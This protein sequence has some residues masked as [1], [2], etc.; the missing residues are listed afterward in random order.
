MNVTT[1]KLIAAMADGRFHTGDELGNR[2]GVTRAAVWKAVRKIPELG[3]ELHSVRG[4]G[5]RLLEP[6]T[7][8]EEQAIRS[9]V[10]AGAH[11]HLQELEILECVD[12]TNSHTLRRIQSGNMQL[13]QGRS[14]AC[15]AEMQSAGRGRRGRSW[16]SP[17]GHNLYMTLC[18]EFPSGA[19]GL[20][21]LS[22]AVGTALAS[23]LQHWGVVGLGLK[24]PNDLLCA[25]RKLAGVLIEISGDVTGVCQVVIGVGM[26]LKRSPA[27]MD[28]VSQPWIS[29]EEIGFDC[30]LRNQL[31]GTVLEHMLV[32]LD[33][34][35]KEGFAVFARDWSRFD[36][37]VGRDLV[38]GSA[39]GEVSGVGCGVDASGALLLRTETGLHRFVGG[40]I[41][42]RA[43][44]P[45]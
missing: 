6:V 32:A 5:Y 37:T 35:Q 7:L 43:V 40:E 29:L 36:M 2:F 21:G 42:L 31:F 11:K 44:E 19:G 17:F 24:W 41:T 13:Q 4:K 1:L 38:L 10:A 22:L 45:W 3:L 9:A 26:N 23:A 18:R 33:R 34:F 14:Y 8:L 25:G 20:D 30:S 12:S 39:S 27:L 16:T 15:L 28:S